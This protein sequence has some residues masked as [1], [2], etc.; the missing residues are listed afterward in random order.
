MNR[1]EASHRRQRLW[2]AVEWIALFIGVPAAYAAGWLPIHIILLLLVMAAGCW[3]VLWR[4]YKIHL[5]DLLQT[6]VPD[7]E[8]RRIIAI[9]AVAAPA[10][11]GLLWLF[12]PAAVFSLVRRHPEVWLLIICA[13]PL[14]SVLPQ[15]LIYRVFL[16]ERYRPMFGRGT[17]MVAASAAA[18]SFGHIVFHNW[19]AVALTLVGGWLFAR[20][21]QRTS[22]LLLVAVEHA[23][24]GCAV[25]TIGYGQF[26]YQGTLRLFR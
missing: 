9:Y 18:F 13:Y 19:P 23:L 1:V 3:L 15:E 10:M 2:L 25:F 16:F 20:T 5:G 7:A 17:G 12:E 4:R 8:R 24:Y 11:L 26:F 22:C 14:I 6:R 21:Y